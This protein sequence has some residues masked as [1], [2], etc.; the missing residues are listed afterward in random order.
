[1]NAEFNSLLLTDPELECLTGLAPIRDDFDPIVRLYW[2]YE[3]SP[4]LFAGVV[5][6][7]LIIRPSMLEDPNFRARFFQKLSQQKLEK[8]GWIGKGLN[9]LTKTVE[10]RIDRYL[11]CLSP[12]PLGILLD[13]VDH[14]NAII[15]EMVFVEQLQ[16]AGNPVAIEDSQAVLERLHQIRAELVRA[17]KTERLFREN[18]HIRLDETA[19]NCHAWQRLELDHQVRKYERFVNDTLKIGVK[20]WEE[21]KSWYALEEHSHS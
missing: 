1:M 19:F 7:N 8:K 18:P 16:E 15:Q 13:D 12:T 11:Q 4:D 9:K 5:A 21:M 10:K 17:L 14:Y 6:L 3:K 20:V 2:I